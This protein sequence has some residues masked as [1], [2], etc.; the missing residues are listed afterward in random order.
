MCARA[1][2]PPLLHATLASSLCCCAP[3]AAVT[4]GASDGARAYRP[5]GGDGSTVLGVLPRPAAEEDDD[6]LD[7]SIAS[8][9]F[10]DFQPG[11]NRLEVFVR[12]AVLD[13]AA[14]GRND[15][16]FCL[17]DF[18]NFESQSTPLASGTT[19]VRPL[20]ST[21]ASISPSRAHRVAMCGVARACMRTWV[22]GC[23]C[24]TRRRNSR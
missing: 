7:A 23:R 18:L 17:V 24:T 12:D 21:C 11:E 6:S 19:P 14:L 2:T 1:H 8:S 20:H 15:V 5:G 9:T 3:V 10:F 22:C 16:T 4:L 13:P